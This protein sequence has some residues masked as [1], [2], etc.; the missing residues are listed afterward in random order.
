MVLCLNNKIL[1]INVIVNASISVKINKNK[2]KPKQKANKP[3]DLGL[4]TITFGDFNDIWCIA[5][6]VFCNCKFF[7]SWEIINNSEKQ[8][9]NN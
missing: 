5:I 3:C 2:K 6:D 4:T 8:T 1:N 9:N 7:E